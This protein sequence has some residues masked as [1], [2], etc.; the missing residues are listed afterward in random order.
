MYTA[1]GVENL[2]APDWTATRSPEGIPHL[3]GRAR[4]SR[5]FHRRD[6]GLYE[7]TIDTPPLW[8]RKVA[9]AEYDSYIIDIE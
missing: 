5:R 6:G 1:G 8:G 9:V 2:L 7:Y 4:P 3:L